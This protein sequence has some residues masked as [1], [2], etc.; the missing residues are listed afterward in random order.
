MKTPHLIIG[1]ALR[2][3]AEFLVG[4]LAADSQ[5]FMSSEKGQC[6]LYGGSLRRIAQ[7]SEYERPFKDAAFPHGAVGE[8][9]RGYS[10]SVGQ[11]GPA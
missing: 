7:P 4:R 3:G 1:G 8:A 9:S 11:D 6:L 10:P 5:M 2:N